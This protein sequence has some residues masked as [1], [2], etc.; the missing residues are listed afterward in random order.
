MSC[1]KF[2]NIFVLKHLLSVWCG[3][4]YPTDIIW[5]I[6]FMMNDCIQI[7]CGNTHTAIL[8]MCTGKVYMCG[9]NVWDQ[10]GMDLSSGQTVMEALCEQIKNSMFGMTNPI[11]PNHSPTL[12]EITLP[13]KIDSIYCKNDYSCAFT[14][15]TKY[16]WGYEPGTAFS[17][18]HPAPRKSTFHFEKIRCGDAHNVLLKSDGMI[19]TWGK[20]DCGQLGE[21]DYEYYAK[22]SPS[23]VKFST[24]IQTFDCGEKFTI[25]LHTDGHMTSLGQH[26]EYNVFEYTQ[27]ENVIQIGCGRNHIIA[28]TADGFIYAWGHNSNY[29]LGLGDF[30]YRSKPQKLVLDRIKSFC[31]GTFHTI[32]TDFD[33]N[34]YSWGSNEY[35]Q[36]GLGH[37]EIVSLPQ[38][39][40]LRYIN[41]INCGGYHTMVHTSDSKYYV[42]G[43]NTEG[44]LGL[45][46][47]INRFEPV[48]LKLK[49]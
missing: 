34:V 17:S 20:N 48:E 46:D 12:R 23:E 14:T 31:C 28:L 19:L 40:S 3:P 7:S 27:P 49:F 44:Q 37:A 35:G 43:R 42:W 32:A 10:L 4:H 38:K 41:T 39:L 6:I 29:Q 24:K 36:L 8:H 33:G 22:E 15:D 9:N 47:T 18:I 2:F 13:E 25:L 5:V 26:C 45:T 30:H 1:K 21:A 11:I 16:D